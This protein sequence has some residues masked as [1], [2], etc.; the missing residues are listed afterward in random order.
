MGELLADGVGK[1][2]LN[3]PS[4]NSTAP[5]HT[6]SAL[7]SALSPDFVPGGSATSAGLAETPAG[8]AALRP[9]A[10]AFQPSEALS[11]V[12]ASRT[13][14]VQNPPFSSVVGAVAFTSGE[15]FSGGGDGSAEGYPASGEAHPYAAAAAGYDSEEEGGGVGGWGRRGAW[16]PG[17]GDDMLEVYEGASEEVVTSLLGYHYGMSIPVEKEQLFPSG[18]SL[19]PGWGSGGPGGPGGPGGGGEWQMDVEGMEGYRDGY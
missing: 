6:L 2:A 8:K 14:P 5:P 18:T 13:S 15:P 19:P 11:H 10:A 9:Q 12:P 16:E 4:S 1:L 17:D 7:F 3:P